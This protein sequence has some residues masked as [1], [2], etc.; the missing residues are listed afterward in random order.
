L[1]HLADELGY[2]VKDLL[3]QLVTVWAPGHRRLLPAI[4]PRAGRI[5]PRQGLYPLNS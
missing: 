4:A 5:R 2:G 1:Q 3:I